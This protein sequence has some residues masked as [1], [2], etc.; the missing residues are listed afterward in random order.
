MVGTTRMRAFVSYILI[1][2]P[3][4]DPDNSKSLAQRS[5]S[6]DAEVV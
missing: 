4:T 2:M 5:E 6:R 3:R 1:E